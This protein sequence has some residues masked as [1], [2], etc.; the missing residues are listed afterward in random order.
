MC[1]LNGRWVKS[2]ERLSSRENFVFLHRVSETP[3]WWNWPLRIEITAISSLQ[4]AQIHSCRIIAPFSFQSFE[5]SVYTAHTTLISKC[6]AECQMKNSR[7][8]DVEYI[9]L[10]PGT[11]T[12]LWK[13][14]VIIIF[15]NQSKYCTLYQPTTPYNLC[16]Q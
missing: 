2:L 16:Q 7:D 9:L 6:T 15:Y 3:T 12:Y 10:L 14:W 8:V 5:Q 13:S 1:Y 4:R 11:S